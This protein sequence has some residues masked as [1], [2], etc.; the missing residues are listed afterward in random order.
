MRSTPL[1]FFVYGGLI[2]V[3]ALW[4]GPWL[5]RVAGHTA[6]EAAAGLFLINLAML[7]AFMSW[8]AVLPRLARHG[9]GAVQIMAWGLPLN[10]ALITWIVLSPQP[11]GAALWAAWCVSCTFVSVSQPAVGQAFPGELAG[12]ALSAF[13]LVIFG[14]VFAL[15]WGI[16]LGIDLARSL[17]LAEEAAFRV[18][19]AAFGLCCVASYAFFLWHLRARG[20]SPAAAPAR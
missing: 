5:T 13:N 7:F 19:F 14:G 18:T 20:I 12:R 2:A 10:L 3:Q 8:G 16:G 11:A 9:I 1:G 6:A 15:Q 4:A 17:G